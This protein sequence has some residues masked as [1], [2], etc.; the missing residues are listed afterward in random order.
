MSDGQLTIAW[1]LYLKPL[2]VCCIGLVQLDMF[3]PEMLPA[4]NKSFTLY[5]PPVMCIWIS[6]TLYVCLNVGTLRSLAERARLK[7]HSAVNAELFLVSSVPSS[8]R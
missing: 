2:C 8:L 4:G 5:A 7:S 3:S 6:H 1:N